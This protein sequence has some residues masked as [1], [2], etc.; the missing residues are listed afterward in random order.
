M[1]WRGIKPVKTTPH[2]RA[3]LAAFCS[4]GLIVTIGCNAQSRDRLMNF[5][6]E[7]PP[8]GVAP[9]ADVAFTETPSVPT[10]EPFKLP[11]ARFA[12]VHNPVLTRECGACHD[13]SNQMVPR[14]DLASACQTCHTEFVSLEAGHA[15]VVMG[16]CGTCHE[17]HRSQLAGLLRQPVL[18]TCIECHDEPE[19]LSEEAHGAANVERCTNCHDPHFGEGFLLKPE[20][21]RFMAVDESTSVD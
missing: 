8:E 9:V 15:P 20:Y 7:I 5:F 11:P 4:L 6:F 18:D 19:D 17:M 3:A 1:S 12:V 16:D 21:K 13:E 2:Q 14:E 10:P